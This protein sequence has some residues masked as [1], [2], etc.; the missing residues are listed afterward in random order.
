MT[1]FLNIK[2]TNIR[3]A[4]FY[5]YRHYSDEE[6]LNQ[7]RNVPKFNY[8][9]LTSFQVAEKIEKEMFLK[10]ITI[11][12]Y[13]TFNPWSKVIAYAQ[14]DTIFINT[15]KNFSIV[16]RVE[17]IFHETMHI[18]GFEHQGNIP[19]SFNLKTVPYL[20]GNIFANYIREK[21]D[22]KA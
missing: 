4:V 13:K 9:S 18:I 22:L 10:D 21:H 19:N 16:D 7:I 17:T 15:R 6:F 11:T 5:V 2:D 20:A 14:N 1:Y 3:M 8:T 12:P